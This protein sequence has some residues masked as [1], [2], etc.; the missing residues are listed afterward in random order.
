MAELFQLNRWKPTVQCPPASYLHLLL[1]DCKLAVL[2]D[3]YKWHKHVG[4]LMA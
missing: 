3:A 4:A 1:N 2:L